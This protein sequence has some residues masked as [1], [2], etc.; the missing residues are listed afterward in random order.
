[1]HLAPAS[2]VKIQRGRRARE[3]ATVGGEI[4]RR[5]G[6]KLK[7][8]GD[9]ERGL[10]AETWLELPLGLGARKDWVPV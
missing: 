6:K 1:M 2:S 5:E 4:A 9:W 3:K 10:A 8:I 7:A